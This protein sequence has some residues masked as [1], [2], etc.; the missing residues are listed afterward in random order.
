M[1]CNQ[2]NGTLFDI[3]KRIIVQ[4]GVKHSSRYK[5]WLGTL[6][7]RYLNFQFNYKNT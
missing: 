6:H 5:R 2:K 7:D 4:S 3:Q 1:Y